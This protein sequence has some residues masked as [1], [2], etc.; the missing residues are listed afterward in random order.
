THS[1]QPL[2][3][4]VNVTDFDMTGDLDRASRTVRSGGIWWIGSAPR[5]AGRITDAVGGNP[6]QRRGRITTIGALGAHAVVYIS[7]R[8]LAP[9]EMFN[10]CHALDNTCSAKRPAGFATILVLDGCDPG[11]TPAHAPIDSGCRSGSRRGRSPG[12]RSGRADRNAS[13]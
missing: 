5:V 7:F 10:T 11:P 3:L 13:G 4:I 2:L 6:I 8:T 12:N 9:H 1:I